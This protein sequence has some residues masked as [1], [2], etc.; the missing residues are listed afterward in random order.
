M[1]G[2]SYMAPVPT[3]AEKEK[4]RQQYLNQLERLREQCRELEKEVGRFIDPATLKGIWELE[5]YCRT[6][7]AKQ[8]LQK[9][10]NWRY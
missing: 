6:L 10:S 2:A 3:A 1:G 8:A 4:S 9:D 5:A 7:L